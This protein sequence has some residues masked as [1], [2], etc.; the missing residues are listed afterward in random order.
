MDKVKEK[1]IAITKLK[2]HQTILDDIF[3][4]SNNSPDN[5]EIIIYNYLRKRYGREPKEDDDVQ[6]WAVFDKVQTTTKEST[7]FYH[8][9]CDIKKRK[10]LV[11]NHEDETNGEI[12]F[13]YWGTNSKDITIF[14]FVRSALTGAWTMLK[15]KDY[16][17][18]S[19]FTK[20]F[21]DPSRVSTIK[22]FS[23]IGADTGSQTKIFTKDEEDI[24]QPSLVIERCAEVEMLKS[25][26]ADTE[27]SNTLTKL[28]KFINA[29][30]KIATM[31]RG[32]IKLQLKHQ[33]K[34]F[35]PSP[36]CEMLKFIEDSIKKN[37]PTIKDDVKWRFMDVCQQVQS[38]KKQT[39]KKLKQAFFEFYE[40]SAKVHSLID[41]SSRLYYKFQE[42]FN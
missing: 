37:L 22:L 36:Y 8:V 12:I 10:F 20:H 15:E 39:D 38:V 2:I 7:K 17:F 28:I 26:F 33:N 25:Y 5:V 11:S 3:K 24:F 35:D 16:S 29:K 18:P 19:L 14:C 31:Q 41:P 21:L 27:H 32:Q 23:F 9:K 1:D 42:F 13:V 40:D 34:S 30:E 4:D 6:T